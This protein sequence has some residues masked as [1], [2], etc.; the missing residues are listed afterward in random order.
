MATREVADPTSTS[1]RYRDAKQPLTPLAGP[2]GH[3]F[4]PILVT[5]PIGAWVTSLVLDIGTRTAGDPGELARAAYWAV[6][7]GIVGALVAAMFGLMDL[8][9]IPR[10]SRAFRVGLTHLALNLTVLA[11]FVASLIWRL[12]RGVNLE[13]RLAQ[14]ILSAVAL[15]LLV[16][17]G[18]LGGMLTYRYGVRVANE[19][20]QV[21]GYTNGAFSRPAATDGRGAPLR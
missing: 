10:S 5:I 19:A 14:I 21:D 17:S 7:I 6:A 4:H 11:M 8:L 9:R 15:L 18:W 20:D 12:S 13:T 2:Y 16:V 3:P 1:A